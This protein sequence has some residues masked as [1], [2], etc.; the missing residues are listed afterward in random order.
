MCSFCLARFPLVRFT[1]AVVCMSTYMSI[2]LNDRVW[3]LLVC[4]SMDVEVA[5]AG[6]VNT[7]IFIKYM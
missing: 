3:F 6:G 2:V 1:H 5:I 4:F 7:L